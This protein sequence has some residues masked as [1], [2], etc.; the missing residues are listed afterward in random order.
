MSRLVWLLVGL[1]L[2]AATFSFASEPWLDVCGTAERV[3]GT[4][5]F[6]AGLGWSGLGPAPE[7]RLD[8]EGRT[9]IR[10]PAKPASPAD[11]I[12]ASDVETFMLAGGRDEN[13]TPRPLAVD[14]LGRVRC[15]PPSGRD[16]VADAYW[17]G[18][19]NGL[20]DEGAR[21]VDRC[22]DEIE[23]MISDDGSLRCIDIDGQF[24]PWPQP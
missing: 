21:S 20:E 24:A 10:C 13:R 11:A 4:C 12:G 19:R 14:Q 9:T 17:L 6:A 5:P 22:Y 16:G 15:A 7:V 23:R 2:G 1:V 18:F 8:D 3:D